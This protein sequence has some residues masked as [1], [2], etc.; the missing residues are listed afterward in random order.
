MRNPESEQSAPEISEI[1]K[2]PRG[3]QTDVSYRGNQ[4]T[5]LA[6]NARGPFLVTMTSFLAGKRFDELEPELQRAIQKA[7]EDSFED[8]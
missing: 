4:Y 1:I 5:I 8:Q 7:Y 6:G 3:F 2:T